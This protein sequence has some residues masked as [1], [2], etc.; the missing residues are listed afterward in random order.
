MKLKNKTRKKYKLCAR[1]KIV[2]N[3]LELQKK[4]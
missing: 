1:T 3:K 2:P 4:R